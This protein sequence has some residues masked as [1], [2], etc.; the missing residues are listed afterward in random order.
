MKTR[1]HMPQCNYTL[2]TIGNPSGKCARIRTVAASNNRVHMPWSLNYCL[3]A[4]HTVYVWCCSSCT[5]RSWS[6]T[7]STQRHRRGCNTL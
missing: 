7:H 6:I 1:V 3:F 5:S 2:V 4:S